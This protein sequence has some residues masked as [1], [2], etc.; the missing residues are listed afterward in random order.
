MDVA[1]SPTDVPTSHSVSSSTTMNDPTATSVSS[2]LL[3]A[4]ES[5]ALVLSKRKSSLPVKRKELYMIQQEKKLALEKTY[6]YHYVTCHNCGI[7]KNK[8]FGQQGKEIMYDWID[9]SIIEFKDLRFVRF[10]ACIGCILN[11]PS[12]YA[13]TRFK[14]LLSMGIEKPYDIIVNFYSVKDLPLYVK[15]PMNCRTIPLPIIPPPFTS[16][17]KKMSDLEGTIM[18]EASV[19]WVSKIHKFEE[20]PIYVETGLPVEQWWIDAKKNNADHGKENGYTDN[21]LPESNKVFYNEFL[22]PRNK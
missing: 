21:V 9:K 19:Y 22:Y 16:L 11:E 18:L 3:P 15:P 4:A 20:P 1:S 6:H 2:V 14:H 17:T 12:D 5:Q 7:T 13:E 8:K 10:L